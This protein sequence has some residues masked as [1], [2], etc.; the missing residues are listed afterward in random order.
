MM[1]S[2][3]VIVG[4]VLK[5]PEITK[6][7][8]GNTMAYLYLKVLRPFRSED[9]GPTSDTFKILLWRGIAE[10]CQ[11]NCRIGTIVAVRG[12][13]QSSNYEKD[14]RIFYNCDIIAEKVAYVSN[15]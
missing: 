14:E 12:R 13:L 10:E 1:L 8:Q 6:T 4:E 11:D 3:C 9:N 7:A 15:S 5:E 2:S